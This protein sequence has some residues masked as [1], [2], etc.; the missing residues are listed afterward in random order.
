MR[1]EHILRKIRFWLAIFIVGLVLSGITA[2]PLLTELRWF[3]RLLLTPALQPISMRIGL[4][5]WIVRVHEGLEVTQRDYPFLAYGTDWLAFAH[6]VIA[7][8]LIGP[9]REPV[10]NKWV[11][12]FGLIACAGILPLALIAGAVRGIPLPWRLVDCSFGVFGCIP[13]LLCLKWTNTLE[14]DSQ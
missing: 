2:F 13:L 7:V 1:S 9:Y 4:L 5:P 14:R 3:H 11:I 8:A 10:R 12:V 6:L